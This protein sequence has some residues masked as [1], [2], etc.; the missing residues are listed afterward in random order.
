MWKLN[1]KNKKKQIVKDINVKMKKEETVHQRNKRELTHCS[2]KSK[3]HRFNPMVFSLERK[4]TCLPCMFYKLILFNREI[5]F[6]S[7]YFHAHW[8]ALYFLLSNHNGPWNL[9]E[10]RISNFL[11]HFFI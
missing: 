10:R 9:I 6:L 8:S 7:E 4:L 2:H 5:F 1:H 3:N 11:S